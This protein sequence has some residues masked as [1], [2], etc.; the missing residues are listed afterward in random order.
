MLV[1]TAEKEYPIQWLCRSNS[2]KYTTVQVALRKNQFTFSRILE[3]AD[4]RTRFI[5]TH[6]SGVLGPVL[7]FKQIGRHLCIQH[8]RVRQIEIRA[9]EHLIDDNHEMDDWKE[10]TEEKIRLTDRAS[11]S[12]PR[13]VETF[14]L[15]APRKQ[16][17]RNTIN[18]YA[19][20]CENIMLEHKNLMKQPW[21]ELPR[22]ALKELMVNKFCDFAEHENPLRTV[23]QLCHMSNFI[24]MYADK[25][26][27]EFSFRHGIERQV[28]KEGVVEAYEADHSHLD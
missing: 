20:S 26:I 13:T 25:I 14:D 10:N 28:L 3:I 6:R 19:A 1:E 24:M 8:G 5:L 11:P 7:P 27:Q 16:D 2:M 18:W 12:H 9:V 23:R 22:A 17:V 21:S 4:W 15:L